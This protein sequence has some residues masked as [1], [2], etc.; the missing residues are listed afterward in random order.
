MK[1]LTTYL[2]GI[3]IL[4]SASAAAAEGRDN[5]TA[6]VTARVTSSR[7]LWVSSDRSFVG[8]R[9]LYAT[10][11]PNGDGIRDR[12]AI[13][14]RLARA[15][16]VKLTIAKTARRARTVYSRTYHLS[17]GRHRLYWAPARSTPART[18]LTFLTVNGRVYGTRSAGPRRRQQTPAIR[19]LGVDAAFSRDSY[20]SGERAMLRVAADAEELT[21]Q[22]FRVGPERVRTRGNE[23]MQGVPVTKPRRYNWDGRRDGVQALSIEVGAWATGVYFAKLVTGDGRTGFAS[24]IVRPRRLGEHAIAVVLPTNTWQAYNFRDDDGNGWGDTWYAHWA[25]RTARVGRPQLD[26]GVPMCFRR[27]D[28]PF[29]NW[30]ART[31]RRVDYLAQRD[32]ELTSGNALRRA[33]E[34]IVFPGHHEYVTKDE[35]NAVRRFRDLGGNLMFL[36]ANNFFWRVDRRGDRLVKIAQWRKLGRPEAALIGVQYVANNSGPRSPF[37]VTDVEAAPWLWREM[38]IRNG[39]RFGDDFGIEIDRT[40]ASSPGGTRVVAHIPNLFGAALSAQMTYYRTPAGAEVFAAGVFTLAGAAKHP[41]GARLLNNLWRQMASDRG[42]AKYQLASAE[43]RGKLEAA[44]RRESYRPG[45]H[46]TLAI[47]NSPARISV[48][49]F[50]TGP[51]RVPT[52]GNEQMN[53]VPASLAATYSGRNRLTIRIG[54]WKSGLYFA[55]VQASRGR[56]AYAPF[57]VRPRRLGEHRIA[58]VMPTLTWQAYNFRDDD[59]DGDADTWYAGDRSGR[60]VRL[61]RPYLNR[62]V[63]LRFRSYD[64]PF[65]H[66]L[67]WTNRKVDY[68]AQIDLERAGGRR[69]KRVYDLIVFPGHHEYVTDA[70]FDAVARFRDLGGNLAFLS[71]NNF[72][73]KVERHGSVLH[74]IAMWRDIGRPE[75]A[76]VGVQYMAYGSHLRGPYLVLNTGAAPWLF[77][78]TGLRNGSRFGTFGIEIDRKTAASPPGTKVLAE[79][80]NRQGRVVMGQMAYYQTKGGARVFAAGAFTLAGSATRSY[81][82]GLLEN[83]WDHLTRG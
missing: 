37:I 65:L 74:K 22:V 79:V 55:R 33:Y 15:G 2:V 76:L 28:L 59:R 14:V 26:R 11:S 56:V 48:Q 43:R 45:E 51:E 39:S 60:T 23:E 35:Y 36:S 30:L 66:W 40:T 62:G 9:P 72:F 38:N 29:L 69:L 3:A 8:D 10:I 6:S 75:A 4:L 18:Y 47:W 5:S 31:G 1:A 68:L 77:R 52:R 44:F 17:A 54:A 57:V 81:G 7:W 63:P 82:A 80:D 64:L 20:A 34:L 32:L 19:V 71:A 27:Y 49:V 16:R 41:Y 53:G 83:L 67:A 50:R 70:E 42:T 73:W 24:F 46:A 12:A 78:G 58:V 13:H 25:R 21:T 61:G